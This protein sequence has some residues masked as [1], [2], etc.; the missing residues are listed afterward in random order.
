MAKERGIRLYAMTN[1]GG[2]TWDF[3]TIPYEPF[4]NRWHERCES[5]LES[6]RRYGLTGL[7]ESHHY[8]FLPSF[9]SRLITNDFTVGAPSYEEKLRAIAEEIA[10]RFEDTF[11]EGM[12]LYK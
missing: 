4:P 9:I 3:G 5:I 12:K 8:G 10:P 2:R 6:Q 7:M 1:T 11:I